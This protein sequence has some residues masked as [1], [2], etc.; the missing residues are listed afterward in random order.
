MAL[1]A[2]DIGNEA[3]VRRLFT[4]ILSAFN[5]A[6]D[7]WDGEVA[8]GLLTQLK[9]LEKQSSSINDL[10]RRNL[11]VAGLRLA[12]VVGGLQP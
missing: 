3:Q 6:C 7:N 10:D 12:R 11:I 1:R 5:Q 4:L 2:D 9:K 8:R